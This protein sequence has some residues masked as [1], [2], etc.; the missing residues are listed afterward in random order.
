MS[1]EFFQT[2][3]GRKFYEHDVPMLVEAILRVAVALEDVKK[4]LTNKPLPRLHPRE[5]VETDPQT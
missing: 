3:M 5:R 4:Q 1:Q 2:Y